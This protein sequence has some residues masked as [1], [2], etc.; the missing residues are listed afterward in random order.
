L[1]ELL[2]SVGRHAHREILRARSNRG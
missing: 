1:S 2:E